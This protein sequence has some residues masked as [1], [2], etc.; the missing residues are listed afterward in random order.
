MLTD[1]DKAEIDAYITHRIIMFYE[2]MKE[3]GEL[4]SREIPKF[5][6]SNTK[7]YKRPEWS[8]YKEYDET[9]AK[10]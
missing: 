2:R 1:E 6:S 9:N 4:L 3:D 5:I 7:P 10:Q 8:W